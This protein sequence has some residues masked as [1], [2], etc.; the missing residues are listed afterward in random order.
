MLAVNHCQLTCAAGHITWEA[1]SFSVS[2]VGPCKGKRSY[3]LIFIPIRGIQG[4]ALSNC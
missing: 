3:R 2:Y 1:T 4:E